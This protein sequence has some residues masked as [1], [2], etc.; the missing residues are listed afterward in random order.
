MSRFLDW[1]ADLNEPRRSRHMPRRPMKPEVQSL[2]EQ[3][4]AERRKLRA[5]DPRNAGV[6]LEAAWMSA[7]IQE[8]E[9]DLRLQLRVCYVVI[10][11]LATTIGVLVA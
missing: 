1:L 2:F 3:L 5:N 9:R 6:E 4:T 11:A 7:M 8:S 10:A